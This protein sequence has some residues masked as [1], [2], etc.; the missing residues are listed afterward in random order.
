MFIKNVLNTSFFVWLFLG[1]GYIG[2]EEISRVFIGGVIV[3]CG[4]VVDC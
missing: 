2:K 4:V 3:D 1:G